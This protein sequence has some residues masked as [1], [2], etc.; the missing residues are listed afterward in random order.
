MSKVPIRFKKMHIVAYSKVNS[1]NEH[2]VCTRSLMAPTMMELSACKVEGRVLVG[3]CKHAFHMQCI[4]DCVKDNGGVCPICK[5]VWKTSTTTDVRVH[6]KSYKTSDI[7][8]NL[9][10]RSKIEGIN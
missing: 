9:D 4:N 7:K 5:T 1:H 10:E 8:T 2:C 6:V 3:E